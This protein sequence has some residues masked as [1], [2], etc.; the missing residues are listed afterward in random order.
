M[1]SSAYLA[2]SRRMLNDIANKVL[3]M[4]EELAGVAGKL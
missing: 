1:F 4:A 3:K 2:Q